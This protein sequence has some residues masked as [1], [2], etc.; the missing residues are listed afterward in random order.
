MCT[1][2]PRSMCNQV[3][4]PVLQF[5]GYSTSQ[6]LP[7]SVPSHHPIFM[8]LFGVFVLFHYPLIPSIAVEV[9]NYG[10]LL[11]VHACRSGYICDVALFVRPVSLLFFYIMS[12]VW[13]SLFCFLV[14][15]VLFTTHTL[16][17]GVSVYWSLSLS[18]CNLLLLCVCLSFARSHWIGHD[19]C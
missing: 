11:H 3:G 12:L 1:L 9:H 19:I 4:G 18:L 7:P 6:L 5:Q 15:L 13:F 8:H 14:H 17:M 16:C 10:L 2:F